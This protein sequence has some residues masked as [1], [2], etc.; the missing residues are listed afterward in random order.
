[1][2]AYKQYSLKDEHVLSLS[3]LLPKS[4]KLKL[5]EARRPK[6]VG[7]TD[8]S[9]YYLYYMMVRHST[10]NC[11]T[12]KDVLQTLIDVEVLKLRSEQKKVMANMTSFNLA[13]SSHRC[14]PKWFPSRKGN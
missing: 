2:R 5:P 9:N 3:K 4:K 10:K 11:Y 14:Q 7:K 6:E 1:M 8:D 13:E 12:F